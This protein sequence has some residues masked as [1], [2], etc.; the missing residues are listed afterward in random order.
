M[1]RREF[2]HLDPI[3]RLAAKIIGRLNYLGS[4]TTKRKLE[5]SMSAHKRA[6]WPDAWELL[7]ERKCIQLTPGKRRQQIVTLTD[8]PA[9]AD[10]KP[11]IKKKRRKRPQSDWFKFWLPVFLDR[12]GYEEK[13][14][15]ANATLQQQ[16][17]VVTKDTE[18]R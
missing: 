10:P 12:D 8:L 7:L 13:A 4:Q 17:Y 16:W 15:E 9:W 6:Y 3:E 11:V 1:G 14:A 5:R 2:A 18:G